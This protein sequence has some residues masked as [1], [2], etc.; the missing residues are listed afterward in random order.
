MKVSSD[1]KFYDIEKNVREYIEMCEG[2]DGRFLIEILKKHLKPNSTVLELGM[3]SG[4]DLQILNK[5]YQATGS[6]YSQAFLDIYKE[7]N[8]KADLILLD[9]VTLRT[10]RKFDCVYSNKVLHHLSR[11][12]LKQS[13]KH[14][15]KLLNKNGILFHTFWKG[16][17]EETFQDLHF[18]QYEIDELKGLVKKD[19]EIIQ[20][21]PYRE[22][23]KNDSIYLILKKL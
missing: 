17:K 18:I 10:N 2:M 6:D 9:S 22:M 21:D 14:Q 11:N 13:F 23:I 3:G 7:K 12:N 4:N 16:T 1:I 15:K 8:P 19:Y 5:T 20:I